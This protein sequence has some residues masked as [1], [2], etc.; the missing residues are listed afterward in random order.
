MQMCKQV[1]NHVEVEQRF[2]D[3]IRKT[4]SCWVW[5]GAIKDNGY[6]SYYDDGKVVSAHRYSYEAFNGPIPD[7]FV[8][9]H[10]CRTRHCV[11]P[12]HLEAVT[13]RENLRRG[14]GFIGRQTRQTACVRGHEL[15]GD[16][17][18]VTPSGKRQC[19]ACRKAAR[20]KHYDETGK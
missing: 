11:N 20:R 12:D 4:A 17:L 14:A 5:I 19:R 16:N 2:L 8:I 6:G 13:Q 7:G 18:Y 1:C 9:D 15:A 3:K 10:L